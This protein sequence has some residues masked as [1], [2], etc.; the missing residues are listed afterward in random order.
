MFVQA[1]SHTRVTST[2]SRGSRQDVI[3][4][5]EGITLYML[6]SYSFNFYGNLQRS[7]AMA[8]VSFW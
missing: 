3:I 8:I 6:T 5:S 1:V 7:V 2:A 4:A